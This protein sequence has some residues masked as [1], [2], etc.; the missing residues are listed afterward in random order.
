MALKNVIYSSKLLVIYYLVYL[1][2]CNT[3]VLIII[4][5]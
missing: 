5:Y 1:S 3:N 2:S 4:E